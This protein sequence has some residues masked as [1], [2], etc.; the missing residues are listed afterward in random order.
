V[1]DVDAFVAEVVPALRAEV[2]AL[3]NGDLGPRLALWS[4]NDPVTLFG[5]WLSGRGWGEI[6]P[7]FERL[8][9]TFHG[10]QGIEYEVLAAGASGDLG[11]VVAIEHS[12]ASVG[13]E[14]SRSYAL[15]VTTVL[16]RENGRWKVVHRHGDP[17]NAPAGQIVGRLAGSAVTAPAGTATDLPGRAV[18]GTDPDL[19]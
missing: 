5:A 15:R 9:A 14:G 1:D 4:R 13:D 11:Y 8:A 19:A 6:E 12:V 16:R 7:A 18:E 3:H 2:E 17:L 10:S